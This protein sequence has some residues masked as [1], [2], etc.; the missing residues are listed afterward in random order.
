MQKN[1]IPAIPI[2]SSE[3][4]AAKLPGIDT[5]H[6]NSQMSHFC[7]L[8]FAITKTLEFYF[9]R[10]KF[11]WM[12][13]SSIEKAENCINPAN[14]LAYINGPNNGGINTNYF[15]LWMVLKSSFTWHIKQKILPL[16]CLWVNLT[17]VCNMTNFPPGS[18]ASKSK[19]V[20]PSPWHW[21]SCTLNTV[22]N[23]RPSSL[24]QIRTKWSRASRGLQR[25]SGVWSTWP[26][27]KVEGIGLV[28]PGKEEA[29]VI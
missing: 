25:R 11:I 18:V 28:Q 19:E 29:G 10:T 20:F 9:L 15:T 13:N 6:H 23:S 21:C 8:I 12:R 24:R 27:K 14:F 1:Q 3:Y 4:F 2:S 17:M 7:S 22:S 16:C 26:L 5:V